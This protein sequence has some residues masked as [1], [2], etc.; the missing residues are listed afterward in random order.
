MNSLLNIKNRVISYTL[1]VTH[2]RFLFC[3][4]KVYVITILC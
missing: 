1:S 4:I 3:S 2:G